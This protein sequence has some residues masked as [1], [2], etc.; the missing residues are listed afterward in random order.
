MRVDVFGAGA[1]GG[2]VGA[3]LFEAGVDV[4]LVARRAHAEALR[5]A[6]FESVARA[7]I[8]R[9]NLANAVE[10]LTGRPGRDSAVARAAQSEGEAVPGKVSPRAAPCAPPRPGWGQQ[11]PRRRS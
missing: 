3:R 5:G 7:D 11:G 10:A 8:M 9:W 1:I 4:T 2:L 6:T